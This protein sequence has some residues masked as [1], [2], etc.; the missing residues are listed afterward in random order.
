[1]YAVIMAGGSGTRLWPIS[2]TSKPKQFHPIAGK[3]PLIRETFERLLPKFSPNKIFI[4]T[5][6]KYRSE[7]KKHLPEIPNENF[8]IEPKNM[9]TA[10]ACGLAS[11]IIEKRDP[12]AVAVFLPSDHTIGD[13]DKFLKT[14]EFAESLAQNYSERIITI[15]VKPTKPDTGLGYIH[16]DKQ[17]FNNS[18]ST[19][20]SIK[21]FV[22]KPSLEKAKQYLKSWDFLWNAGIFVWRT[23]TLLKLIDEH[24]PKTSNCLHEITN[25]IDSLEFEKK[26]I[27]EY[28]KVEEIS[29][30]YGILE[31]TSQILVVPGNFGWSDIGS[32]SSLLEYFTQAEGVDVI[33]H[34]HHVGIKDSKCLVLGDNKLIATIGL[35]DTIIVDSPDALLVCNQKFSGDVKL[36]LEK[37]KLEGEHLY[38]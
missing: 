31:K 29:I 9:G 24:L 12:G 22:E 38:L 28:S 10:P 5:T 23:D 3:K 30:D 32:W 1:M 7:I 19:A 35:K 36:L 4:S 2:R 6:K 25:F 14:I 33:S 8:I 37:L 15:G 11:L 18:G 21:R 13:N 26:L 34:G 27:V 16:L 20:F 17:L